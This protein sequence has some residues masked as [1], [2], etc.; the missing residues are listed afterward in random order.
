M[1]DAEAPIL[2]IRCDQEC[3][4][5]NPCDNCGDYSCDAHA[6]YCPEHDVGLCYE[7]KPRKHKYCEE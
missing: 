6:E 4:E 3:Y 5:E 1:T 2:C 7:C